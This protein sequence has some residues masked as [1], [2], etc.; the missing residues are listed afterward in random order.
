MLGEGRGGRGRFPHL[1]QHC[2]GPGQPTVWPCAPALLSLSCC[3]QGGVREAEGVGSVVNSKSR[4]NDCASAVVLPQRPP[5][6]PPLIFSVR[7]GRKRVRK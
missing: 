7:T 2:W 3:R 6:P 4:H 5:P 1:R